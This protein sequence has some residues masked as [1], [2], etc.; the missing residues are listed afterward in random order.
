MD[1][2][3]IWIYVIAGALYLISRA[4][5]NK[6]G[7]AT[8]AKPVRRSSNAPTGRPNKPVSFE[9]L[10]KEFTEG[11]SSTEEEEY[12]EQPRPLEARQV[13][14]ERK[15][16]QENKW[17]DDIRNEGRNRKFADDESRRVYE[18][19]IKNAE[20]AKLDFE[21]DEHFRIKLKDR[22][23]EEDV[24]ES[25]FASD[26]ASM[27]RNPEDARKAVILGEILNRKY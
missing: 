26:I 9:E 13:V 6:G 20:G 7:D 1:D 21:R 12:Q 15:W 8:P 11:N 16:A 10:L 22:K 5:K 27:L 2:F 4:F 18:E 24:N 19:S 17:D 14:E 23:K 25:E 3:K